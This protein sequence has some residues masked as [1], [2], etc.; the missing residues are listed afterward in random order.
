VDVEQCQESAHSYSV[1]AMPTF[2]F[3]KN[4]VLL[5]RIQG[6]DPTALENKIKELIGSSADGESGGQSTDTGVAG[7]I[8]LLSFINKSESE[9][10]NESDAHNLSGCLTSGSSNYL[11]S[12]CDEQLIIN[13][14]FNQPLKLHSLKII[15]PEEN[16]PKHIKLFINQPRTLDFDQASSMEPIQQMELSAED[17]S[18]GNPIPLRY[19]KFQNVQNLLVLNQFFSLFNYKFFFS[20]FNYKTLFTSNLNRF[21]LKIISQT[22]K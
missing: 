14:A 9:C 13:L 1:Q 20:L 7:H 17:I 21:L 16:G 8:D 4:K 3:F 18:N 15:A 12:D 22:V 10:L 6:A 2:I 11:E 19:V 5:S